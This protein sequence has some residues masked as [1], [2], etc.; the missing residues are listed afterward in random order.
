MFFIAVAHVQKKKKIIS[1]EA[2]WGI[3]LKLC[4]MSVRLASIKIVFFLLQLSCV[5][6]LLW[7]LKVFIGLKWEKGTLAFIAI[8]L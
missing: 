5:L 2:I 6:S 1:S 7:Q 8:S 4:R 3:K